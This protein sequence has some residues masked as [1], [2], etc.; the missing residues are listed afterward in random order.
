MRYS[1]LLAVVMLLG[2]AETNQTPPPKKTSASQPAPVMTESSQ[3]ETRDALSKD[4]QVRL[5]VFLDLLETYGR[6]YEKKPDPSL[7]NAFYLAVGVGDPDIQDE[8]SFQWEDPCD[9]VLT[10][11]GTRSIPIKKYSQCSAG[12]MQCSDRTTGEPGYLLRVGPLKWLDK[13]TA[14]LEAGHYVHPR[15]ASGTRL[16]VQRKGDKWEITRTGGWVS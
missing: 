3:P 5:A 11:I 1:M 13:D 12:G 14:T 6:P 7:L 4:D 8:S 15:N 2:C 10:A 16:K 9:A